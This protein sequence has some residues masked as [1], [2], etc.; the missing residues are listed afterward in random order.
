MDNKHLEN[1]KLNKKG[2]SP[3]RFTPKWIY[4]LFLLFIIFS[5]FS[6]PIFKTKEIGW[7]KFEQTMLSQHDVDKIVIVNKEVQGLIVTAYEE[8]KI[9]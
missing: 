9:Y 4:F 8:L 7:P 1:K 2:K 5:I 6:G 3:T